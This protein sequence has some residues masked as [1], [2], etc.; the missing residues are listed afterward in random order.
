MS[1]RLRGLVVVALLSS[2]ATA[3]HQSRQLAATCDERFILF[4]YF[5]LSLIRI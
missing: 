5:A 4:S 2:C 1:K 3:Y